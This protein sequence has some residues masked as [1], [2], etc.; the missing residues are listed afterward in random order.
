MGKVAIA[1]FE[2]HQVQAPRRFAVEE[3]IFLPVLGEIFFD[4]VGRPEVVAK[5]GCEGGQVVQA[6]LPGQRCAIDDGGDAL[7][8]NPRQTGA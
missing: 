2:L 7:L 8:A 4:E 6:V 3:Q 5:R 1:R